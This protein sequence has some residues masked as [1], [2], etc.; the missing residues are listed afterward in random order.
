[1]RYL[2]R[3]GVIIIGVALGGCQHVD[4][5]EFSSVVA[6]DIDY[7][8]IKATE[9]I[10]IETGLSIFR[11]FVM[12]E[13]SEEDLSEEEVE[14]LDRMQV[15]LDSRKRP[16]DLHDLEILDSADMRLANAMFWDRADDRKCDTQDETFSLY[17]A[18][19]FGSIDTV[20]EYQHRRTALQEIRFAIE[21]ASGGREFD[22]RMMDFNNLP[23]TSFDDVK[24]VIST[25]RARLQDRLELQSAC[26]L[27]ASQS[28]AQIPQVVGRNPVRVVHRS[29]WGAS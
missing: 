17:C 14:S 8:A 20:G 10:E 24:N 26:A 28:S 3:Y 22:H 21:N 25:V 13:L 15:I 5:E 12:D 19:Y 2:I 4:V 9:M 18:L 16:V 7:A 29:Q 23:E 1:M 27:T 6:C 11:R